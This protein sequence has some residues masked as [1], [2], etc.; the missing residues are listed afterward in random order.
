MLMAIVAGAVMGTIFNTLFKSNPA[1]AKAFVQGNSTQ[2]IWGVSGWI[3]ILLCDL[4]VSWGLYKY[5]RKINPKKA[6]IMGVSRLIYS[7]ILAVGII[8]LCLVFPLL[9]V[10]GAT[11]ENI[12]MHIHRFQ[13]FWEM[14]LIVFGVH[15]LLLASLVCKN[16]TIRQAISAMLFLAG[17]GYIV[18]NTANFTMEG[19]GQYEDT[20]EA[21]FMLPMILG[22]VGLAVWLLVRGGKA[23]KHPRTQFVCE[24][25]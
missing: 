13:Y 4:I 5:Y 23:V 8:N 19:Y 1:D 10:A 24:S 11:G 6:G 17:V 14:G 15:L 12:L 18:T 20:L 21:V 25:C 7:G 22:E 2:Y 3:V 16:G 9:N